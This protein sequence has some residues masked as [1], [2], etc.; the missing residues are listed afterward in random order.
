MILELDKV[1]I[2]HKGKKYTESDL[3]LLRFKIS[4]N[5]TPTH[6]YNL[7]EDINI[8]EEL[9]SEKKEELKKWRINMKASSWKSRQRGLRKKGKLKQDQ[10]DSLNRF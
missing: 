6:N 1:F 3:D 9:S 10:I 2:L 8:E 5:Y 4:E 7:D